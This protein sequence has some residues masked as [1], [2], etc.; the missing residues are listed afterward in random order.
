MFYSFLLSF[1]HLHWEYLIIHSALSIFHLSLDFVFTCDCA[2]QRANISFYSRLLYEIFASLLIRY[3]AKFVAVFLLLFCISKYTKKKKTNK[4]Q[5]ILKLNWTNLLFSMPAAVNGAYEQRI[6]TH[7]FSSLSSSHSPPATFSLHWLLVCCAAWPTSLVFSALHPLSPFSPLPCRRS[8]L[9]CSAQHIANHFYG[10]ASLWLLN[11][12]AHLIKQK[13]RRLQFN[14]QNRSR[15]RFASPPSPP[16]SPPTPHMPLPFPYR[17]IN[18][19]IRKLCASIRLRQPH[20]LHLSPISPRSPARP[21]FVLTV[22]F[23]L[24]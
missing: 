10:A 5:W 14:P 16:P 2:R 7:S 13:F 22:Q 6:V 24:F 4:I 8:A 21:T 23:F 1:P 12:F 19:L 17:R 11:F 9:L 3:K 18:K 15:V 20:S